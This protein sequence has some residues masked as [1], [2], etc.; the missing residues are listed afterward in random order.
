MERRLAAIMA[1]DVVGYSRLIRADEEGTIAALKAL[2]ADL[3]DPKI[4]EHHGRIVKL[5]GDGM[6][7]EFASVVHAVHAAVETQQAVTDH[8]ADVPA[9]KRIEL[10][11]GIN[12]GDVVIDGDDIQGDGVNVASRLESM[13]EPGGIC[14]SGMVYEG[15]RDRIE[16]PFKDLGEQEVKN[17]ERPV[18]VWRWLAGDGAAPATPLGTTA[19]LPLPDKP[20]IAVLPFTNMSGDPEQEFFADGLAEDIITE[21][22]REPDLFVIARNSSFVYKGQSKDIKEIGRDLGA[23]YVLEGSV[24]KAGNRIRLTAQLIDAETN[25]HLWA[26]RYDRA[27]EDV[28]EVQDELTSAIYSTLLKKFED[29]GLERT[30]RQKPTHLD[31]YQ[32]VLRAFGLLHRMT[33]AD[34]DAAFEAAE[35]AVARDPHFGRAHSAMAWAHMYRVFMGQAVDPEEALEMGRGEAQKAIE[36]ERSDYWGYAALGGAELY[37]GHHERALSAIE[38]AVA[39]GPNNAEMRALHAL[40]LNYLGRP[41]EGLADIGLA[42]RLNPHHPDWYLV[43]WGRSLYLLGRHEEAVPVLQRLEDAGTELLQSYLLMIANHMAIDHTKEAGEI[44]AALLEMKPDMTVAQVPQIAP[45][46]EKDDLDRF[47]GLL[48][49]AGLPE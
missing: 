4:A 2:R 23:S 27:L 20:S 21:L 10:R 5:M 24:R 30:I 14:I 9:D 34:C 19:S 45:F 46:K 6:L 7:A 40:L 42:V 22:S 13:A 35:A 47:L 15:V 38:R 48:R 17:I 25:H 29:I 44:L 26:E 12:L 16:V 41:E 1:T 28:F 37:L 18:R 8:N 36:A 32:L 49:E 31:A 39:L 11:I 33:R 3:I 43:V